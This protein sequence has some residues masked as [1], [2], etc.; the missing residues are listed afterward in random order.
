MKIIPDS[1]LN[2][3]LN[4]SDC[5]SQNIAQK[6]KNR[7]EQE[8]YKERLKNSKDGITLFIDKLYKLGIGFLFGLACI[9]ILLILGCFSC[10]IYK[11][12]KYIMVDLEKLETF[13]HDAWKV[14]SG[15]SIIL[16]A[17]F[18]GWTIKNKHHE[19]KERD[20]VD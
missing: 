18:L 16:F 11:Y 7:I 3:E 12:M 19:L 13:L 1:A 20:K 8:I 4:Q 5:E 15:A 6:E 10:L 17:Q 2:K 14:L 9:S